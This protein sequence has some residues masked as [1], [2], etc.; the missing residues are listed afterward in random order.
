[1]RMD[2]SGGP[3]A[4]DLLDTAGE[5]ELARILRAY[6]EERFASRIAAGIARRREAGDPAVD[7]KS[8][9]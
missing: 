8:V 5:R 1:M 7:R 9:V 6:G 4:Q 2:Q 3:T